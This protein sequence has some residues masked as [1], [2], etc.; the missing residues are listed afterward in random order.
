MQSCFDTAAGDDSWTIFWHLQKSQFLTSLNMLSK[1]LLVSRNLMAQSPEI[2]SVCHLQ[3]LSICY[4]T[5]GVDRCLVFV[6]GNDWFW[7][8]VNFAVDCQGVS[9]HKV[10]R[11]G[12]EIFHNRYGCNG[13]KIF[14]FAHCRTVSLAPSHQHAW[15][16]FPYIRHNL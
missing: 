10:L 13:N 7:F 6:P 5:W 8:T 4:L 14:N 16:S 15:M 2:S 9:L 1:N 11:L 3:N 12:F